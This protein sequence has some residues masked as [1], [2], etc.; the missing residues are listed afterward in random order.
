LTIAVFGYGY[1][2]PNLVRNF[3]SVGVTVKY[4]VDSN[5]KCLAKAKNWYPFIQVTTDSELVLHD[6]S[7]DGIVIALP[8]FLH[9]EFARR[10]LLAGKH[11]LVE[12]PMTDSSTSAM[13]LMELADKMNL[14]LMPDH[15]FL[16]TGAVKKIKEYIEK[17]DLGDIKYFDSTRV[18]LGLF[19]R[20]ISVIWDLAPH[21][22][23][24]LYYLIPEKP[25][26]VIATGIS[27]TSTNIENI[28]Y[29]TLFYKSNLIVHINI[30]WI[31]PVKIRKILIGGTKKMVV[32]DDIEPTEKVKIYDSGYIMQNA[33]DISRIYVEYRMGDIFV[34]KLDTTEALNGLAKDFINAAETNSCPVSNSGLGLSVIKILE[35]AELSIKTGCKEVIK[36]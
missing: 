27:H 21:D 11:V 7:V 29:L 31:S 25:I 2:G 13:A 4:I 24:I 5:E 19:Q 34:P 9:Y 20:D 16:Y 22:L 8:V 10:A 35:A 32:Y 26:S 33:E 28:A 12:K 17:K 14:T 1:W 6:V 3:L 30:S 18:N 23:S 15:T 36:P